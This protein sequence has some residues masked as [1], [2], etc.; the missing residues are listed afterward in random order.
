[1]IAQ[2]ANRS[3]L[4]AALAQYRRCN[5]CERRCGVDRAAG[6]MGFCKAKTIPRLVRHRIEYGEEVEI[7]P[8]HQFYLSGCDLRCAFC[9]S[10]LNSFDPSRGDELTSGFFNRAVEW[11]R[12][13]GARTL[14]WVGGEPTIHLPAIL[15]VMS[16]CPNLPT[17][18]WKSDFYGVPDVFD[19][20]QGAVDLYIADFKFGNDACA[21][22]IAGVHRYVDIITRNL[23][24]AS[25]KS[26]LIVRHLLLPGH[27]ECCYRPILNWMTENLPQ[28]TFSLR[29]SYLP[30][31]RSARFPELAQALAPQDASRAR[32]LAE[33]AGLKVIQ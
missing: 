1:M 14:Q 24:I 25:K 2:R 31:W 6:E 20:L 5:L 9:I 18:I 27:A 11:G 23:L 29:E 30:S 19:L 3:R 4:N 15:D 22:R 7:I 17:I 16:H 10:G 21:H 32:A 8:C 26:R 12:G 33:Q 13:A 28:V